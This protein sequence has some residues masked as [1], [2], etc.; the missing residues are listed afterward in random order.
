MKEFVKTTGCLRVAA[1]KSLDERI[2]PQEPQHSCCSHSSL[3]WRCG[4]CKATLPLFE[5]PHA[6][7]ED[8]VKEF[9]LTRPVS[10]QDKV[11]LMDSLLE[12]QNSL[13]TKHAV[14]DGVS[15]HGFS[16]QLVQDVVANCY[17]LFTISDIL[18]LCPVFSI[19]HCL[20]VLEI[21]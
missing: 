13:V 1:Y 7:N 19:S 9:L 8:S 21:I 2:Q 14:F 6:D 20:K 18:E 10:N 4:Q 15:C 5:K 16:D 12:V 17:Y 11:D 3:N